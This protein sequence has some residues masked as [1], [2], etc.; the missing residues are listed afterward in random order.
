VGSSHIAANKDCASDISAVVFLYIVNDNSTN[1]IDGHEF[2]L[3][4]NIESADNC[5][6][7][8]TPKKWIRNCASEGS[9]ASDCDGH[10]CSLDAYDDT[11]IRHNKLLS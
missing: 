10:G 5:W 6:T 8:Y 3:N 2:C 1:S 11:N 7:S 4:V 9:S